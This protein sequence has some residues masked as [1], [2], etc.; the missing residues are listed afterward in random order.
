MFDYKPLFAYNSTTMPL[1]KVE[2]EK[3]LRRVSLRI[4][5]KEGEDPKDHKLLIRS[6]NVSNTF[7]KHNTYFDGAVSVL[8]NVLPD[9]YALGLSIAVRQGIEGLSLDTTK[10]GVGRYDVRFE[11]SP[12]CFAGE[13][14]GQCLILDEC[15]QA[16]VINQEYG[17]ELKS[18][19]NSSLKFRIDRSTCNHPLALAARHKGN[20]LLNPE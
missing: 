15:I 8:E 12:T 19:G 4:H 2:S 14:S 7:N 6:V 10:N 11:P 20:K 3:N 1:I 17:Y 18:H 5:L 16:L 9:D 13:L